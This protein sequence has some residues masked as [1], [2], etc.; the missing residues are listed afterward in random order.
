MPAAPTA[1]SRWG[2]LRRMELPESTPGV[3]LHTPREVSVG[4]A[5]PKAQTIEDPSQPHCHDHKFFVASCPVCHQACANHQPYASAHP[6]PTKR[7]FGYTG[8]ITESTFRAGYTPDRYLFTE[9]TL[10]EAGLVMFV[11]QWILRFIWPSR[12]L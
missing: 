12:N 1:A 11:I 9:P 10:A 6:E 8:P 2:T 5:H 7:S 3:S 4:L